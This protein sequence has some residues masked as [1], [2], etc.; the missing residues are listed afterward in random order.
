MRDKYSGI[1]DL[2][3]YLDSTISP[4]IRPTNSSSRARV[5]KNV[6]LGIRFLF[7]DS[8]TLSFATELSRPVSSNGALDTK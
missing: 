6:V 8:F 1:S 3:K 7:L 2:L 4:A 5:S